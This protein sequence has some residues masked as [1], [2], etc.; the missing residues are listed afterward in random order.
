MSRLA[1]LSADSMEG[2]LAGSPGGARARAWIVR[3]LRSIGAQPIGASFEQSVKLRPRAGAGADTVGANIIARIPGK[4]PSLPAIV[5]SAHYDHLGIRN[6]EVFNGADDDASGCIAVLTIAERVKK[7]GIEHDLIVAFF[8]AE[9]S[10]L[11]GAKAFVAAPSVPLNRI[12]I[13]ISLDM[14]SRQDNGALWVAG[15]S[16]YPFLRDIVAPA[17]A[18]S[19][20][21]ILLGH[22]TKDLKPGDDWTNSSD[23]GAFHSK[24][25]PFLYLGVEDHPDYHKAGDE[26]GKI[27]PVFY[28]G[29]VDFAEDLLRAVDRAAK[30]F[31]ARS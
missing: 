17:A 29:V 5:L 15:L 30:T 4:N 20:V 6:G 2:R 21:K 10:G 28:R 26:V 1:A 23:H 12:A 11:L 31:P 13:D 25:I 22:D 16:H 18:K 19:R 14:V 9:E 8:D 3:E 27:D 24:G 7:A